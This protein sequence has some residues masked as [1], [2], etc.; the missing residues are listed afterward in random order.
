MD[1]RPRRD[2]SSSIRCTGDESRGLRPHRGAAEGELQRITLLY[3][4]A[5]TSRAHRPA[6]ARSTRSTPGSSPGTWSSS[7]PGRAWESPA[8]RSAWRPTSPSEPRH[9]RAVHAR[10]VEVRG[11]PAAP[12]ARKRRSSRSGSGNGKLADDWPRLTR[13]RQAVERADLR[14]RHRVDHDMERSARGIAAEDAEPGLSLI[15]VDYLQLMTSGTSV[16]NRVQEVSEISRNL[17]VL[18]RDLTCRSSRCRRRRAPS[19]AARQA[20]DP[21]DLASPAPSSS[22]RRSRL[23]HLRATTTTGVRAA[24]PRRADPRQATQRPTDAVKLSFLKRYAKFADLAA[25]AKP[26]RGGGEQRTERRSIWI[27]AAAGGVRSPSA[28]P[29][30]DTARPPVSSVTRCAPNWRQLHDVLPQGS[31]PAGAADPS[32]RIKPNGRGGAR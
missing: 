1:R 8:S 30:R 31:H 15:I 28:R 4:P 18:A 23:L 22:G 10:D 32:P 25:N 16:E 21:L 19:V 11:D 9:R 29:G 3:R 2:R 26:P 17:K 7:R 5:P 12:C 13:G 14:R 20:A 6:S 27:S 24:G